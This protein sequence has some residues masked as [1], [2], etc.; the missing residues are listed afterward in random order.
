MTAPTH[1]DDNE[2]VAAGWFAGLLTLALGG[3]GLIIAALAVGTQRVWANAAG[4]ADRNRERRN[5]WLD[6]QRAWLD[7]DHQRRLDRARAK[8]DWI[9][10]GSDPD[11]A[12]AKLSRGHRWGER[13]RRGFAHTAVGAHDF[14]T[15][16][17]D[18]WTNANHIRKDGGTFRDVA[19]ARPTTSV[20]EET[21][22]PAPAADSVP[23]APN[24]V[25]H[26]SNEYK[27]ARRHCW[28][29][30][31]CHA[32][33]L[34]YPTKEAAAAAF[35]QHHCHPS[36]ADEDARARLLR[37][38]LNDSTRASTCPTQQQV[39]QNEADKHAIGPNPNTHEGATMTET[40]AAPAAESN[41]TVLRGD[42]SRIQQLLGKVSENTDALAALRDEL[43]TAVE[44]ADEFAG[45]TGQ[46]A[47]S[48]QALDEARQVVITIGKHL[49]DFSEGAVHAEDQVASASD[50]LRVVEQ[51]EDSLRI[52]GADGRAVAP[53]TAA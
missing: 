34:D 7:S 23:T 22:R 12:P 41:A 18:G 51:A 17:K 40:T 37:A 6:N 10:A 43:H 25:V 32:T 46:S 28:S 50:G 19:Q 45:A 52:A 4:E 21:D 9:T 8:R 3:A 30:D 16:F 11:T 31:R 44:K 35:E 33:G 5:S 53:A 49:G 29:C 47:Q 36:S 48:R 13:I 24:G 14:A 27:T 26:E 38:A 42:L 1:T 39:T 2:A 20:P 15:G